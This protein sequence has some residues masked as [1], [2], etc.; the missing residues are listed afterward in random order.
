MG[1]K[2][3]HYI[4]YIKPIHKNIVFSADIRR[5]VSMGTKRMRWLVWLVVRIKTD[6]TVAT[7]V[8]R[9]CSFSYS[10]RNFR[11]NFFFLGENVMEN[12]KCCI[13]F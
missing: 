9:K 12:T 4:R 2:K 5:A 13:L 11:D 1:A 3:V 10:V 6:S 8:S 7:D